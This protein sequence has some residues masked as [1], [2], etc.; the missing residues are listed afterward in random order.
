MSVAR[1]QFFGPSSSDRD[2]VEPALIGSEDEFD[3]GTVIAEDDEL[4]PSL[5]SDFDDTGALDD[6]AS[7]VSD[8][9]TITRVPATTVPLAT[10]EPT[11]VPTS[12]TSA[13][14][15][16]TSPA[17]SNAELTGIYLDKLSD[18]YASLDIRTSVHNIYADLRLM[19]LPEDVINLEA[20]GEDVTEWN[21]HNGIGTDDEEIRL[22]RREVAADEGDSACVTPNAMV[23]RFENSS[24]SPADFAIISPMLLS[25]A[26]STPCRVR[27]LEIA[28]DEVP[29]RDM[30]QVWGWSMLATLLIVI[31]SLAG[32]LVFPFFGRFPRTEA[33]LLNS[34]M[35]LA[36]GVLF[37]DAVLHLLPNILRDRHSGHGHDHHHGQHDATEILGYGVTI[38]V[39]IWVFVVIDDAARLSKLC[40]FLISKAMRICKSRRC[41][42]NSSQESLQGTLPLSWNTERRGGDDRSSDAT[43][44]MSSL[45]RLRQIW[46]DDKSFRNVL[47]DAPSTFRRSVSKTPITSPG[48]ALDTSDDKY[49]VGGDVPTFVRSSRVIG[50]ERSESLRRSEYLADTTLESLGTAG[51][52]ASTASRIRL[53]A[54]RPPAPAIAREASGV[55][56]AQ[57]R[58]ALMML[59]SD[60][61]HNFADGLG[62]GT[63]FMISNQLGI[64]TTLAVALH[65]LPH[66]FADFAILI[67]AGF[68][69][70]T[71]AILNFATGLTAFLGTFVAILIL[72]AGGTRLSHS[73][74]AWM[75]ENE[76]TRYLLAFVAG[77]F[78]YLALCGLIVQVQRNK[79]AALTTGHIRNDAGVGWWVMNSSWALPRSQQN[80]TLADVHAP[81][82]SFRAPKP[83]E[84]G[85]HANNTQ[86]SIGT[87][88]F[89]RMPHVPP[90]DIITR[91]TNISHAVRTE[92]VR[93]AR[94][95]LKSIDGLSG[96]TEDF[97]SPLDDLEPRSGNLSLT[98]PP[99]I[100][101][102]SRV[103][104][105]QGPET[106]SCGRPP[107]GRSGVRE[108]QSGAY[109]AQRN[110]LSQRS[111]SHRGAAITAGLEHPDAPLEQA[112][113]KEIAQ[114]QHRK[115]ARIHILVSHLNIML[116]VALM[117]IL[118]VYGD[119]FIL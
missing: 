55:I 47:V 12:G 113:L 68:N 71:A 84:L 105:G 103:P 53:N 50:A 98:S 81:N 82:G 39:G 111:R 16:E 3:D 41:Q 48:G 116:G 42:G 87:L 36:V 94:R 78:F 108:E 1:A 61:L 29:P 51:N 65:E 114:A 18:K 77:N 19:P 7:Q 24:L 22:M 64:T 95:A 119:N 107:P 86:E 56:N 76:L 112:R 57:Q 5:A 69:V 90:S 20:E 44:F 54:T 15:S 30:S 93:N 102:L 37:G 2:P 9:N 99:M 85:T 59:V 32:L 63:G 46:T 115:D 67:K 89:R 11:P 100:P 27:L 73:H 110:E 38:F 75:A 33:L 109:V 80:L 43:G 101:T 117:G 83:S 8:F 35:S 25:S 70:K 74:S 62:I 21:Q 66:E 96:D 92:E 104:G 23:M 14:T 118:A 6:L 4:D 79:R 10:S 17:A 34:L 91:G 45:K 72:S 106:G 40:D 13:T 31:I 52:R 88:P 60:F 26:T 28:L 49:F 97:E 58:L